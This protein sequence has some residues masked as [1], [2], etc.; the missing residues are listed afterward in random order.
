MTTKRAVVYDRFWHSQ[1]GGERHSGMIA[2]VLANDGVE[3]DLLGHSDVDRDV[4]ADHLGLDLSRCRFRVVP[5]RGDLFLE[6]L[7]REYDLFVNGTYGSRL[8]PRSAHAAYLC[9]FPTPFDADLSPVRRVLTLAPD[10]RT[11]RLRLDLGGPGMP[12]PRTLTITDEH[13]RVITEVEVGSEFA[14]HH[15]EFPSEQGGQE[16]HFTTKTFSPGGSDQRELGVAVSRIRLEGGRHGPRGLLAYRF[17]WLLRDPKNLS[18]LTSYDTVMANSEYTRGYISRFWGTDAD[19]LFP[20]I[21]VQRLHPAAVRE[22]AVITVGRFFS[23]GLGHA[24]RQLEMVEFFVRGVR[25]GTI[26]SDWRMYVVGGMEE[27]QRNYVEQ[28]RAAGAGFP[29][30]VV[31]NAPRT[32]VEDLLSTSSVFWSATGYGEDERK[33]PWASEHF[34][35]TTVEAMAAGCVPVVIDRAGQKEIVRENVD[36]FRWTTPD[37]LLALTAEVAGDDALRARLSAAAVTRA[38]EYSEDA[39]A[40]RWHA[41][42]DKHHLLG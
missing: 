34:G 22:K 31:A 2:E 33:T 32:R 38:Q 39:F 21:Q 25:E 36:G 12:E 26:P 24:K 29:V 7:S 18:F 14:T 23:P 30:E 17:P 28:V 5:D 1:G 9:Y 16:L 19:L 13:H 4:L 6:G 20:P 3:V 35:M 41:I 10:A 11:R 42:V 40:E 27:S 37:E 8:A 15:V